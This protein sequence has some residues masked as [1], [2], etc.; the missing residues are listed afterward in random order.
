MEIQTLNSL[1]LFIGMGKKKCSG[2]NP[3]K[4]QSRRAI[5]MGKAPGSVI[6][7]G[8]RGGEKSTVN[9]ME[10]DGDH[11][12]ETVLDVYES[13]I[14]DKAGQLKSST[15]IS[16]IDVI[17]ISDEP[18]MDSL[19][20]AFNIN[21]LS[22]EDAI[23]TN[24]RPK[25]DEYDDYIFAVFKMLY[26]DGNNDLVEEHVAIV[27]MKNTVLVMQESKED[28]FEPLRER[29][30]NKMG[31]IRTKGS[32]YLF[33]SLLDAIIDNYFV[34]LENISTQIETLEEEVYERP[35]PQVAHKIQNLKKEILKIRRW[36]FPVKELVNRLIDSEHSLITK[37]TKFFLRDAMD[38]CTEINETLQ[39]YRE[40]AMSL[41]EMYM[42]NMSNKMNEVMK[43]LTIM[44]S[45]FIPLTF[46]VGVYGMN[47]DYIPELKWQYGYFYVWGLMILIFVVLLVYFKKKRWL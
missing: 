35:Q 47:F 9:I 40:M 6:Y 28:V 11:I 36:I 10:Y 38:H 1:T 13:G 44:A 26:L 8:N 30:R 19:G 43:V 46:I 20:K 34:V 29:I 39:V 17:G 16:W 5:K 31:R 27:L 25:I 3:Q 12:Q 15:S 45:I 32:D 37:D 22:V 18:F 7:M 21:P 4:R 41:T 24:Q 33:F 14:F 2:K 23:N 42:G